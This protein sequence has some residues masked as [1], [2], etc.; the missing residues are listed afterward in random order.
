MMIF[1]GTNYDG[2]HQFHVWIPQRAITD[3]LFRAIWVHERIPHS[4]FI[5]QHEAKLVDRS[6]TLAAQSIGPFCTVHM[7]RLA[8]L[9]WD[10]APDS[11]APLEGGAKESS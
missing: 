10:E 4:Q 1:V 7:Y 9:K 2:G 8:D 11:P 5:L 3:D 6:A